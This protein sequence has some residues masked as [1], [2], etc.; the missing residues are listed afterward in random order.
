MGVV[1]RWAGGVLTL[2]EHG[3]K[4]RL[5]ATALLAVELFGERIAVVQKQLPVVHVQHAA[6]L[7]VAAARAGERRR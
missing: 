7:Q 2:H 1:A 3:P 5:G 4:L 6:D